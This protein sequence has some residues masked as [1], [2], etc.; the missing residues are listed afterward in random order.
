VALQIPELA[1]AQISEIIQQHG[2][3]KDAADR[4]AEYC[5]GSPRVADVVGWNLN[6]NPDD[7]TRPLDTGDVWNRFIEG[8]YSGPCRS[9]F[10]AE[11]DHDSGMIPIRIP[12]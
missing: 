7:L 1:D 12:G 5:G 3:S 11:G 2:V 10:R 9:P 6:N 4:S 8:A